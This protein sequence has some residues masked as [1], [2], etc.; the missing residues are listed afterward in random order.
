FSTDKHD[1]PHVHHRVG[2]DELDALVARLREAPEFV[3]DLETTSL[4]PLEAEVVGMAFS[5]K[6]GEA[7]YVGPEE[8]AVH[9][10]APVAAAAAAARPGE[11]FDLF[12]PPPPAAQVELFPLE[13]DFSKQLA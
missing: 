2:L 12:A 5:F 4:N 9:G 3:F 6:E 13:L 8:R 10:Q 1:D 7:W 11:Q